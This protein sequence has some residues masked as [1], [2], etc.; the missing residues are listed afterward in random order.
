MFW[1]EA[2]PAIIVG[3]SLATLICGGL[4]LWLYGGRDD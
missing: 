3:L 4:L 1:T 2:I